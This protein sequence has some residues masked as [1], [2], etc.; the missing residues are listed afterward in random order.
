MRPLLLRPPVLLFFAINPACGRPL[1]SVLFSTLT[2]KR[3]PAEVG[4]AFLSAM[5][6][7]LLCIGA[8]D[9]RGFPA[10]S[11]RHIL[12]GAI[13][14]IDLFAGCK[15]DVCLLPTLALAGLAAKALGL[16]FDIQCRHA[17]HAHIE[18][19]RNRLLDLGLGRIGSHVKHD[20]IVAFAD[21]VAFLRYVLRTQ[22]LE[23]AFLIHASHPSSACSACSVIMTRSAATSDTGST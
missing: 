22:H 6:I 10:G 5:L 2:T 12:A 15:R 17:C 1:C 7:S 11:K 14:E 16:G 3:R 4:L 21:V 18:Q 19:R 23:H 9:N 8:V 20:L 13:E